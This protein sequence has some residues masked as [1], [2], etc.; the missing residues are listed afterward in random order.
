MQGYN[1]Y[2]RSSIERINTGK[3]TRGKHV[4]AKRQSIVGKAVVTGLVASML[5]VGSISLFNASPKV[6]ASNDVK[7]VDATP[8]TYYDSNNDTNVVDSPVVTESPQVSEAP[9][10]TQMPVE[11]QKPIDSENVKLLG[12]EDNIKYLNMSFED[13]TSFDKAVNCKNNYGEL[14]SKVAKRYGVDPKIMLAIATQERGSHSA[15]IDQ[16]GGVGIMQIQYSVWVNKDIK[17]YNFETKKYETLHI[18]D[19]NIRD[20][21][22]NISISA[23]YEQNNLKATNYNVPASLVSYNWGQG[24]AQSKIK[25]YA[26]ECGKT[27]NDELLSS[28][29]GFLQKFNISIGN[30]KYDNYADM[31]LSYLDT[32]EDIQNLKLNDDGSIET[33]TSHINNSY[34]KSLS[35]S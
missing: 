23:M 3:V 24:A 8:T 31:V 26:T 28:D 19:T 10:E 27:Y 29:T 35:L 30:G 33:I 11:T 34:Q 18:T 6:N 16:G 15:E 4:K 32:N 13:R 9:M 2:I 14:I 12:K 21:E 7:T 22:T 20:L 1:N 5:I 17:A 25:S